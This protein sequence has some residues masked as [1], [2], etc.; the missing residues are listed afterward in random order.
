[1]KHGFTFRQAPDEIPVERS[2]A[3]NHT[4][5]PPRPPGVAAKAAVWL[6]C[7]SPLAA[8]PIGLDVYTPLW[9]AVFLLLSTVWIFM[10]PLR[11]RFGNS[12]ARVL[13]NLLPLLLRM[14][15]QFARSHIDAAVLLLGLWL[16]VTL[17]SWSTLQSQKDCIWQVAVTRLSQRSVTLLALFLIV[18][19]FIVLYAELQPTD[20]RPIE[21]E[22]ETLQP[23]E[24]LDAAARD[25]AYGRAE[26]ALPG[27]SREEWSKHSP[28]ERLETLFRFARAERAALHADDD[29][30]NAVC[31][32]ELPEDWAA[33]YS[34]RD[35]TITVS[36]ALVGGTNPEAAARAILCA[37][38]HSYEWQLI[39]Q[40]DEALCGDEIL[41]WKRCLNPE[42]PD[43]IGFSE[44]DGTAAEQSAHAFAAE[45]IK[46]VMQRAEGLG[47]LHQTEN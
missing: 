37:V 5:E 27:L 8:L 38:Y 47:A 3:V 35:R 6:S 11:T 40:T 39:E 1:M 43:R 20:N 16:V 26:D 2:L 23:V 31:S 13:Y 28:E 15:H 22:Q 4:P 24:R 12:L 25:A 41:S 10:L 34:R 46:H 29:E 19:A 32:G 14:G 30:L 45:E 7:L 17:L 9:N 36:P 21:A 42:E 33:S 44:D 18:P